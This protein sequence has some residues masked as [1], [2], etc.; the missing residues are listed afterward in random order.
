MFYKDYYWLQCSERYS[1]IY[2][3]L[4][5]SICK[6]QWGH[7]QWTLDSCGFMFNKCQLIQLLLFSSVN[8][9]VSDANVRA[10]K[11]ECS[12]IWNKDSTLCNSREYEFIKQPAIPFC[13]HRLYLAIVS[14]NKLCYPVIKLVRCIHLQSVDCVD[15]TYYETFNSFPSYAH[16]SF[17]SNVFLNRCTYVYK[18]KL[19]SILSTKSKRVVCIQ[20]RLTSS[21]RKMQVLGLKLLTAVS[22]FLAAVFFGLIPI[23]ILELVGRHSTHRVVCLLNCLAGGI[24]LGTS[25]LHM[26]PEVMYNHE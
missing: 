23:K 9:P 13:I 16:P 25:F 2:M 20:H 5:L 21:R 10:S 12:E 8:V 6:F 11:T 3:I 19:N 24:F 15:I 4:L 17:S 1:T 22:L 7:R 18:M 14:L 26:L